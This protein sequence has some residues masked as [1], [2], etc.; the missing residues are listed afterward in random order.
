MD[1]PT[2][3]KFGLAALGVGCLGYA[4]ISCFTG[5]TRNRA[6]QPVYRGSNPVGFWITT[7]LTG[8][9]GALAIFGAVIRFTE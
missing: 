2:A 3:A 1:I 7:V 4:V 9:V 5:Q 6:F 8:V